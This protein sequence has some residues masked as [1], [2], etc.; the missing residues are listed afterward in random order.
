[1]PSP[2]P[3]GRWYLGVRAGRIQASPQIDFEAWQLPLHAPSREHQRRV[4]GHRAESAIDLVSHVPNRGPVAFRP[5]QIED[6]EPQLQAA[7]F[8]LMTRRSL[9]LPRRQGLS[10]ASFPHEQLLERPYFQWTPIEV[11]TC[12]RLPWLQQ[13]R[14]QLQVFDEAS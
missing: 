13:L 10:I 7:Q 2:T 12:F 8:S 3:H 11:P 14:P 6:C 5:K 9:I 4:E 1:M